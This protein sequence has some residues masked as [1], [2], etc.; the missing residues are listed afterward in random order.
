MSGD[1]GEPGEASPTLE[2]KRRSEWAAA[3]L[4][5][6]AQPTVSV[7]PTF[8]DEANATCRRL[9]APAAEWE[10]L[11]TATVEA[12]PAHAIDPPPPNLNSYSS[13]TRSSAPSSTET[14]PEIL[15]A[16]GGAAAPEI[17][18][19]CMSLLAASMQLPPTLGTLRLA[20]SAAV[21]TDVKK[22]LAGGKRKPKLCLAALERAAARS[23]GGASGYTSADG[24]LGGLETTGG[25]RSRT[26]QSH[27]CSSCQRAKTACSVAE[28]PCRRCTR[29]G[30]VCEDLKL[31]KRACGTCRESKVKCDMDDHFPL[32]CS[33]C[34]RL[35]TAC[36][37]HVPT[38]RR[39]AE[40]AAAGAAEGDTTPPPNAPITAHDAPLGTPVAVATLV[41]PPG[42]RAGLARLAAHA[43]AQHSTQHGALANMGLNGLATWGTA[44]SR[45]ASYSSIGSML[46]GAASAAAHEGALACDLPV[47][48]AAVASPSVSPP[49]SVTTAAH[50][51]GGAPNATP[52]DASGSVPVGE[53]IGEPRPS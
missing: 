28:R 42:A 34:K 14:L 33:R 21:A 6:F 48:A 46:Y 19:G 32:P 52:D 3:S 41:A 7:P 16:E 29:L 45:A 13:G 35:G 27:A 50:V 10:A 36:A 18:P 1:P 25:P 44:L 12:T 49:P 51:P 47:A 23:D 26:K 24:D 8:F 38:K 11:L 20:S 15:A 17:A 31:I 9:V 40:G 43:S 2:G 4:V 37:P 5:A 53:H 30:L 22:A 39:R